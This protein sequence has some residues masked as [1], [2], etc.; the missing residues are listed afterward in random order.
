M[1]KVIYSEKG[2]KFW[3][4]VAKFGCDKF[5]QGFLLFFGLTLLLCL[6]LILFSSANP[7]SKPNPIQQASIDVSFNNYLP[8]FSQHEV[9]KVD[10]IPATQYNAIVSHHSLLRDS[11]RADVRKITFFT[12]SDSVWTIA[13]PAMNGLVEAL[14]DGR[15]I[16]SVTLSFNRHYPSDRRTAKGWYSF[17]LD[18]EHCLELAK[19]FSGDLEEVIIPLL[20]RAALIPLAESP[21]FSD[22][23]EDTLIQRRER[24]GQTY[25]LIKDADSREPFYMYT[26][27]LEST[28]ALGAYASGGLIG[29]YLSIV[30]GVGRFV[31]LSFSD[32]KSQNFVS[33][34]PNVDKLLEICEDL[35]LARSISDL[36]LEESIYKEIIQI[37]RDPDT[38]IELTT[39]PVK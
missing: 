32:S 29:L 13:P 27:S 39:P 12:S 14:E 8:I 18:H 25:W 21:I 17:N 31:R 30:I 33:A 20:P 16:V 28:A 26:Y 5:S 4:W 37:Y 38:L 22:Q 35:F 10:V 24:D 3:L 11:N 19:L 2:S 1:Q 34:L 6:P 7:V 23:R 36:V 9:H 15:G